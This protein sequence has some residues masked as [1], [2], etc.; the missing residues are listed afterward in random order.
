MCAHG[1]GETSTTGPGGSAARTVEVGNLKSGGK[2]AAGDFTFDAVPEE[3]AAHPLLKDPFN[4]D[5]ERDRKLALADQMERTNALEREEQNILDEV[6]AIERRRRAEAPKTPR[7]RAPT[8]PAPRP[9]PA[10]VR[11]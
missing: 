9:A 5:A 6:K 2:G 4:A 11:P 1:G 3:A 7:W 8:A 10:P